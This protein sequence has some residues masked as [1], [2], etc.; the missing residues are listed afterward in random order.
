[1]ITRYNTSFSNFLEFYALRGLSQNCETLYT[2]FST[3]HKRKPSTHNMRFLH[4][5]TY[6]IG[7]PIVLGHEMPDSEQ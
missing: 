2:E 7:A 1:M 3:E 4:L 5:A 6:Y